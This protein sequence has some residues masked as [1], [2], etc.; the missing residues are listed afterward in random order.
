MEEAKTT[1]DTK[2]G[3]DSVQKHI[4]KQYEELQRE[5][6]KEQGPLHKK[7]DAPPTNN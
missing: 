3:L 4:D 6:A 2:H 5:R 1:R 7:T